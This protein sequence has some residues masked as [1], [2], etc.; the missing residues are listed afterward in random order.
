MNLDRKEHI[1]E[2][3]K[4]AN[5]IVIVSAPVGVDIL[6]TAIALA[7]YLDHQ[8]NK[9]ATVIY[10]KKQAS[11]VQEIPTDLPSS[12]E[13]LDDVEKRKLQVRIDYSGTEIEAID[14]YKKILKY[15]F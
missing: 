3:I 12:R 8:F 1:E 10:A 6:A 14:Y 5:K 2:L 7:E 9:N 15:L 11:Q 4:K 13:I